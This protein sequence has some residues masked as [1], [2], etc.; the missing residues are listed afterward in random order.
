MST[1]VHTAAESVRLLLDL[2][3]REG[4]PTPGNITATTLPHWPSVSIQVDSEV[5]LAAWAERTFDP[6][7]ITEHET[8]SHA[9]RQTD[10]RVGSLRISVAYFTRAVAS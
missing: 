1:T 9:W 6:T 5:E 7:P 4:L 8:A 3:D 10:L 2:I